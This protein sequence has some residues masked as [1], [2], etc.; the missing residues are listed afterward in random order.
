MLERLNKLD[1]LKVL[2]IDIQ[3]IRMELSV[4]KESVYKWQADS[5][6]SVG[7]LITQTKNMKE[8][9]EFVGLKADQAEIEITKINRAGKV[10]REDIAMI[11]ETL[12]KH[13]AKIDELFDK[14]A[15]VD[16]MFRK[17]DKEA[18]TTKAEAVEIE[19][20][21]KVI[22]HLT[23]RLTFTEG[24][25]NQGFEKVEK[26]SDK[27]FEELT[28]VMVRIVKREIKK[29]LVNSDMFAD[30][31]K[32]SGSHNKCLMCNQV[33]RVMEKESPPQLPEL[34]NTQP[35][36][37]VHNVSKPK[38]FKPDARHETS[39]PRVYLDEA[40]LK[41]TQ[42]FLTE[43]VGVVFSSG[44]K[45]PARAPID[46]TT[47]RNESPKPVRKLR[48]EPGGPR[49]VIERTGYT[50]RGIVYDQAVAEKEFVTDAVVGRPTT[51]GDIIGVHSSGARLMEAISK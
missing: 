47:G 11:K 39:P 5:A 15:D 19:R 42:Q 49:Q 3:E 32:A 44:A 29:A 28:Q 51:V 36:L 40:A 2:P 41:E 12:E 45:D 24:S 6:E 10:F 26:S 8:E 16:D 13:T 17:A 23:R 27:K 25:M 46:S 20:L 35:L 43:T 9:L 1:E 4:F 50:S 34:P 14:K 48:V 21:D 7:A 18:L 33:V 31:G 38:V 37:H 22:D 30:V